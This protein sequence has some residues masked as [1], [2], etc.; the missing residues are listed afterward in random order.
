M[1]WDWNNIEIEQQLFSD[2]KSML[3]QGE[4]NNYTAGIQQTFKV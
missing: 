1:T 2:A 4:S 3:S